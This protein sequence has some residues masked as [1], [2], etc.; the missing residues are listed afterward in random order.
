MSN[1]ASTLML[2]AVESANVKH[3]ND[4][5]EWYSKAHNFLRDNVGEGACEQ[6]RG[7]FYTS[8]EFNVCQV[9]GEKLPGIM[10][11]CRAFLTNMASDYT[12]SEPKPEA[13]SE[14]APAPEKPRRRKAE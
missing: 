11:K 5:N 8:K 13:P 9:S 4:V 1:L 14:P 2:L 10:D 3:P 6:L 7:I 12:V